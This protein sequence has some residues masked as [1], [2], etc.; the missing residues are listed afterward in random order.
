MLEQE[1]K[2]GRLSLTGDNTAWIDIVDGRIVCAGSSTDVATTQTTLMALL[3]WT[4][5]TFELSS[6]IPPQVDAALAM[7][8]TRLLLEHA[9][10]RDEAGKQRR[11]LA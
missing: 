2:T 5:G 7:P 4:H 9:R 11:L 10:L 6:T 1:R 8:I 3:D